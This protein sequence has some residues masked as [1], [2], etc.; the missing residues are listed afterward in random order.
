MD[1]ADGTPVL[2]LLLWPRL[3]KRTG[4]CGVNKE[5]CCELAKSLLGDAPML[6]N[7]LTNFCRTHGLQLEAQAN[8]G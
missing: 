5:P 8:R 2:P 3:N 4:S 7:A 6:K 1:R